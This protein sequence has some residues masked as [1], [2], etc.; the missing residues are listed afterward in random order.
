MA[1]HI[2]RIYDAP[3]SDDG[4]RILV[5]RLWPRGVSKARAQLDDWLKDAAP[6]P[7]LRTWFDHRADRF[8]DF[9]QK[10][11]MELDTNPKNQAAV[12]ELLE[13][14]K[15]GEVTL[16]YGAQSPTINHAIVLQGFLEEKA[17]G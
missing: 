12:A 5:D 8:D 17:R 1:F 15:K 11:R 7:D 13:L 2:K 3:A 4:Q 10:Y 6:S 14:A 16:L 9:A